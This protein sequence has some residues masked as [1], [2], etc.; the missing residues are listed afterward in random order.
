M[1]II[2]STPAPTRHVAQL[3][4]EV[5]SLCEEEDYVSLASRTEAPL[6]KGAAISAGILKTNVPALDANLVSKK[7][8][9]K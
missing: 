9:R 3:D 1:L 2:I 5:Q 6:S 7:L 4:H 8:K